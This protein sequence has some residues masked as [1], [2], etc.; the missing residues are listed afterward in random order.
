MALL[1]AV[2]PQFYDFKHLQL[3]AD[4]IGLKVR[5]KSTIDLARKTEKL[6]KFDFHPNISKNSALIDYLRL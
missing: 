6:S 2:L 1:R 4:M 5:N 3:R